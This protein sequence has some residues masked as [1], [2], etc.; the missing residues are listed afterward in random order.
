MKKLFLTL[1]FALIRLTS[2]SQ[3]TATYTG[4]TYNNLTIETDSVNVHIT[5]KALI[6]GQTLTN[7]L[8][9]KVANSKTVT[10]ILAILEDKAYLYFVA[11]YR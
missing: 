2:F 11:K 8:Y 6:Y 3:D 1:S 10:Q 9:V 7:D 5:I 4:Y